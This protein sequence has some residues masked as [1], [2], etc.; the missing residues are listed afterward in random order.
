M[1]RSLGRRSASTVPSLDPALLELAV[2]A[3]ADVRTGATVKHVELGAACRRSTLRGRDG[4]DRLRARVVVGAD[5][6]RSTVARLAGVARPGWLGH[7]VGLTFHLDD[8]RP[9]D[10]RPDARMVVLDERTAGS[11][12]CRAAG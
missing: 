8:P 1:G 5:G 3:G 9:T 7:R 12:R 4:V 11:R 2:E 6:I 10:G